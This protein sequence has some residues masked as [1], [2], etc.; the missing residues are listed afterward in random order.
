MSQKS[1]PRMVNFSDLFSR[2]DS[3]D[4]NESTRGVGFF[5]E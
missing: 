4:E 1:F 5:N 3:E 2:V